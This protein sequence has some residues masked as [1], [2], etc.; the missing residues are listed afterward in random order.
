MLLFYSELDSTDFLGVEGEK[1][2]SAGPA[3]VC[4]R[5]N[6]GTVRDYDT[7]FISLSS[8]HMSLFKAATCNPCQ[9][10][11]PQRSSHMHLTRLI[12]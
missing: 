6:A 9:S 1:G 12:L 10:S 8:E 7:L 3:L 5:L 2:Y 11:M 4:V